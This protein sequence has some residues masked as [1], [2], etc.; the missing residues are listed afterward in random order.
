MNQ[1]GF[2]LMEILASTA[3]TGVVVLAATGFM[4]KGL[5]WFDELNAKVEINR[6]ARETF[7]LMAYGARSSAVGKD[8]TKNLYGVRGR[9]AEPPDGLR[10]STD[11]LQ[12][13]SNKLTLNQD[14][15]ATMTITCKGKD[16]PVP[17]CKD[18]HST[19]SVA[20]WI[21]N[22]IKLEAGGKSVAGETVQVTF[23]I[24]NAF[25]A[26]RAVSP[27]QFSNTFYTVFTMNREEDDP[28]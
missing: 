23:T 2:T 12:Y 8:G 10:S 15:F 18:N 1:R 16:L 13:T 17:D 19:Q 7:A 28:H 11:V 6:H 26:Q 27:T 4:I 9:K 3:A 24:T 14:S 20:G 22:D 5:G 21:G 25:Q